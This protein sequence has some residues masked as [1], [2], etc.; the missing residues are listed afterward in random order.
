M[1]R[2]IVLAFEFVCFLAWG[3]GLN[4]IGDHVAHRVAIIFVFV[5][6]SRIRYVRA[7]SW[8][9]AAAAWI[10]MLSAHTGASTRLAALALISAA[11]CIANA[12]CFAARD[13][14]GLQPKSSP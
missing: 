5:L 14:Q 13:V 3:I 4:F 7:L 8:V 12:T 6:I 1:S 11:L 10:G 2:M 9:A